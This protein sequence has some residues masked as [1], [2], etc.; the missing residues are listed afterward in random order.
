MTRVTTNPAR[1]YQ[2]LSGESLKNMAAAANH[3]MNQQIGRLR[4]EDPVF[5]VAYDTATEL[6]AEIRMRKNA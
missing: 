3:I 4:Q 2:A 5:R 6:T 1:R